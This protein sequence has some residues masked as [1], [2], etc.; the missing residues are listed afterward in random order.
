LRCSLEIVALIRA[1]LLLRDRRISTLKI[2]SSLKQLGERNAELVNARR[3]AQQFLKLVR[4]RRRGGLEKRVAAP[5]NRRRAFQRDDTDL[6]GAAGVELR[7]CD[8]DPI[9]V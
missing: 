3:L 4:E 6:L 7:R 5:L 8:G 2:K 1:W 9:A